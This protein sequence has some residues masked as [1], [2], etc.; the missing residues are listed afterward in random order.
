MLH[1]PQTSHKPLARRICL[2]PAVV[3]L[4]VV[5]L[6]VAS[7]APVALEAGEGPVTE[8]AEAAVGLVVAGAVAQGAA[9]APVRLVVPATVVVLATT[10]EV[11]AAAVEEAAA[12][13]LVEE[14]PAGLRLSEDHG[15]QSGEKQELK[16]R[17][18][19]RSD[20]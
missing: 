7:E 19:H 13:A 6:A 9:V 11:T 18:A 16:R 3:L 17:M 10:V 5:W 12:A 15:Q 4:S 1:K 2:I 8:A 14:A 20:L